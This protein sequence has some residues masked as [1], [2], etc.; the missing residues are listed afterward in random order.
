MVL[1]T[2]PVLDYGVPANV[3]LVLWMR[4]GVDCEGL[5]LSG[6]VVHWTCYQGRQECTYLGKHCW[7]ARQ[8]GKWR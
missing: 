8:G 5:T 1:Q 7:E 3:R 4:V 2:Q 6:Q